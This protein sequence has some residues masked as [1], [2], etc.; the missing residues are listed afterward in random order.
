MKTK[1]IIK[2]F[3]ESCIEDVCRN[4][5]CSRCDFS[6]IQPPYCCKVKAIAECSPRPGNIISEKT[7]SILDDIYQGFP[8]SDIAKSHN[9]SRAYVYKLR[10][11]WSW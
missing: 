3:L 10:N 2:L 5:T 4:S 11:K 9:V 6:V 8:V 1:K 7:K